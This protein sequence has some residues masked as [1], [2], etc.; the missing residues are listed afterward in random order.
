M[1]WSAII[2]GIGSAAGGG[3]F[4]LVGAGLGG[5]FKYFQARQEHKNRLELMRVEMEMR[6]QQGAWDGL[7][8]SIQADAAPATYKWVS[9]V[10]ALYRP[11][12]TTGLVVVAL[13]IFW[14]I[15]SGLD[16]RH[17]RLADIL[18]QAEIK[19]LLRYIVYSMIFSTCTAIVW[20]FGDRAFQP[21]GLKNR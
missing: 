20:W 2:S 8:S 17:S 12:L 3:V 10:K 13:V 19:E 9:A 11:V 4:G 16:D 5:V 21:P 18:T 15:L 6:S 14:D 1:D 7:K